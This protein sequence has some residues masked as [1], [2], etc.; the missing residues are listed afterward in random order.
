MRVTTS[1]ASGVRLQ[2]SLLEE[3]VTGVCPARCLQDGPWFAAR[4]VERVVTA[5]GVSLQDAGIPS[6]L[7]L[8]VGPCAVAGV[9]IADS[10]RVGAAKGTV[11]A[12]GCP[13]L[14]GD[15]LAGCH[16]RDGRIVMVDA[17]AG[18][19]VRLDKIHQA[20]HQDDAVADIV[21]ERRHADAHAF[22]GIGFALA[23]ERLMQP[24]LVEQDHRQQVGASRGWKALVAA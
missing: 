6:E 7:P 3:R 4:A 17:L 21:G 11:V 18:E 14:A 9:V 16:H 19:D 8:R 15:G 2:A 12:N 22:G 5:I 10:G 1:T 23:V 13:D 24:E 20:A